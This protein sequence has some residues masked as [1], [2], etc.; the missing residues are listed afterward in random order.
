MREMKK[1]FIDY[2]SDEYILK[3]KVFTMI[4]GSNVDLI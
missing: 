1:R 2:G 3:T 4:L